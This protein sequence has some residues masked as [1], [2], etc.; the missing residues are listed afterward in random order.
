MFSVR[1]WLP[2]VYVR[3]EVRRRPPHA[4]LISLSLAPDLSLAIT[5]TAASS[6]G[7]DAQNTV[8]HSPYGAADCD[9]HRGRCHGY[10]CADRMKRL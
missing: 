9:R 1:L 8:L 5:G 2:F 4:A 6:D 10:Q 3:R 7:Q